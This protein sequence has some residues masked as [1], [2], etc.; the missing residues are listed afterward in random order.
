M[1]GLTAEQWKVFVKTVGQKPEERV[2][3]LLNDGYVVLFGETDYDPK[4]GKSMGLV[5]TTNDDII[6]L[7]ATND[8]LIIN[9]LS[10]LKSGKRKLYLDINASAQPQIDEFLRT[11]NEEVFNLVTSH[12]ER[13][14]QGATNKEMKGKSARRLSRGYFNLLRSAHEYNVEVICLGNPEKHTPKRND[15]TMMADTNYAANN[16]T[17]PGIVYL[18]AEWVKKK[19]YCSI[20]KGLTGRGIINYAFLHE[21]DANQ[22]G[23]LTQGFT[24]HIQ[25]LVNGR[26][27]F[28][29]SDIR[30][31]SLIENKAVCREYD[32][33]V[34]TRQLANTS[35]QQ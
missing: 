9:L 16:I 13:I 17:S 14:A 6:T 2:S 25:T 15:D 23:S 1:N 34:Y 24:A 3:E 20:P 32:G 10:G 18:P 12:L 26:I 31:S 27:A 28:D 30:V 22:F 21:I 19:D 8:A 33:I 11:G 4:L 7:N 5:G 35:R 29:L